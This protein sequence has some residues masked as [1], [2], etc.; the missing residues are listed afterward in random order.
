[1]WIL[2]RW[3][4]PNALI[5]EYQKSRIRHTPSHLRPSERATGSFVKVGMFNTR[6]FI[7]DGVFNTG[8]LVTAALRREQI[9]L[10]ASQAVVGRGFDENLQ[11]GASY[12]QRCKYFAGMRVIAEN[13][14]AK[15]PPSPQLTV[16]EHKVFK[17]TMQEHQVLKQTHQDK[18][19]SPYS[20]HTSWKK[21]EH[22]PDADIQ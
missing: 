16:P 1:M 7:K 13:F 3:R 22:F 14:A 12:F 19:A 5:L 8:S 10:Q 17:L 6:S 4:M 9:T 21:K 11:Q 2:A 18:Q 15:L 20:K